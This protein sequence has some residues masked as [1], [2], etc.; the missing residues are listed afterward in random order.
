[1]SSLLFKV[2]PDQSPTNSIVVSYKSWSALK[3]CSPVSS[4]TTSPLAL[5][6]THTMNPTTFV[7]FIQKTNYGAEEY[8]DSGLLF[9]AHHSTADAKKLG[10][11]LLKEGTD[12]HDVPA[13]LTLVN[14][15][16][17]QKVHIKVVPTS[18]NVAPFEFYDQYSFYSSEHISLM[19]MVVRVQPSNVWLTFARLL[20]KLPN[21]SGRE[22]TLYLRG[23]APSGASTFWIQQYPP[24]IGGEGRLV[25]EFWNDKGIQAVVSHHYTDPAVTR[26]MHRT[27]PSC[28]LSATFL[29]EVQM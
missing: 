12:A 28:I 20:V 10:F 26:A 22:G 16:S 8:T 23:T 5:L 21:I 29:L 14:D 18:S 4:I 19:N 7:S 13:T 25:V 6:N 9:L 11:P 3:L 15:P 1:M 17:G 2:S 27:D 24:Y